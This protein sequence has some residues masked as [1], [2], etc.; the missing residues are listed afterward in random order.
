MNSWAIYQP[1]VKKNETQVSSTPSPV[2]TP[3][4]ATLPF[5]IEIPKIEVK[6]KVVS[7][8]DASS[9]TS[10]GIALKQGVAHALG[11]AFPGQE[12]MIYIFGHSTDYEWNVI[13][14][15]A[16]FYE[17]KDME[18]GDKII[19]KLGDKEYTYQVKEKHIITPTD[20]SLINNNWDNDVLILQTCYPPGTTWQRLLIL[21]EPKN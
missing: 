16:L 3:D 1:P 11:S 14:F 5:S 17:I 6:A 9:E 15:N 7:N 2:P 12:G 20:L 4:P 10:Y 18:N 8:V 19:L 13:Y 21:A